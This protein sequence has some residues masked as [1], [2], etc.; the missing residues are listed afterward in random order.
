M[1]KV[2]STQ[3][4]MMLCWVIGCCKFRYIW[5][6]KMLLYWICSC[7][8][9]YLN[10]MQHNEHSTFHIKFLCVS[11]TRKMVIES[12]G[13]QFHNVATNT[14]GSL[15]YVIRGKWA[16]L[17]FDVRV[18]NA[19]WQDKNHKRMISKIFGLC[20]LGFVHSGQTFCNYTK[21]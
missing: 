10:A 5:K 13:M 7:K 17:Y 4:K 18:K 6:G 8:I 9:W 2:N 19:I 12:F 3:W 16:K 15:C 21:L 20:A 14:S 11:N 1:S